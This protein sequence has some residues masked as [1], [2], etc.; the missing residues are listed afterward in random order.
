MNPLLDPHANALA[1]L[2]RRH[3][4]ARLELFG[5]ATTGTF[6]PVRSDYDFLVAFDENPAG[7]FSRFFDFKEAL[8]ALLGRPCD[9]VMERALRNP[10]FID[11]VNRTRQI[12]Y[13]EPDKQAA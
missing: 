4:V 12:V 11:S 5:S 13:A 7:L 1:A 9:L 2:C 8:E 6:D 10:Y 3:A